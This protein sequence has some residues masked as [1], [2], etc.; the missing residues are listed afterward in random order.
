MVKGKKHTHSKI[1]SMC[2]HNSF[3]YINNRDI[4]NIHLFD[5]G[6]HLLESGMCILTDNFICRLNYFL[7]NRLHYLN[8]HF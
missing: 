5:D 1:I 7:G 8:V 6:F 3:G 4:S 2:K